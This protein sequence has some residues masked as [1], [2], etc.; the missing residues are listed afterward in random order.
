MF[1]SI[2]ILGFAFL[3]T[4]YC[5]AQLVNY[6]SAQDSIYYANTKY[7]LVGP[8]RGGRASGIVGSMQN[9]NVFYMGATGGGVWRTRDAGATWDNISDKYFG[10]TN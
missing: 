2:I 6:A 5:N 1:K 10:G 7:R 4:F 9:K 3:T 8:F